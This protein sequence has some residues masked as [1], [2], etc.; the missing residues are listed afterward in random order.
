VRTRVVVNPDEVIKAFLLLQ[1]V[2]RGGLGGFVLQRQVDPLMAT[3]LLGIARLDAL[4]LDARAC[5]EFCLCEPYDTPC[6][7]GDVWRRNDTMTALTGT[8]WIG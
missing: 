6:G 1:E 5:K 7:G 3:V 4:E 8:C 2:E